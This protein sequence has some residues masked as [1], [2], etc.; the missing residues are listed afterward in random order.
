MCLRSKL[1]K[2]YRN[3][4]SKKANYSYY[5]NY[6]FPLK[7]LSAFFKRDSYR[8]AQMKSFEHSVPI[9]LP[10]FFHTLKTA[11]DAGSTLNCKRKQ[12]DL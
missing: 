8:Y 6:S 9:Y 5:S 11:P 2:M 12:Y 7:F 3:F 10:C 4:G 1:F